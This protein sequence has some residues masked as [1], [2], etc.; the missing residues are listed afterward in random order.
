MD[1]EVKRSI[2]VT[3][4]V[5]FQEDQRDVSEEDLPLKKLFVVSSLTI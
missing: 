5:F 4:E 1:R 2:P 3:A